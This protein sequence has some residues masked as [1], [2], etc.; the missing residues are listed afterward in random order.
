MTPCLGDM[1][2]VVRVS[3]GSCPGTSRSVWCWYSR[4]SAICRRR[5]GM[6]L[7]T[8]SAAAMHS[9]GAEAATAHCQPECHVP[10]NSSS[11][12]YVLD[13]APWP[14]PWQSAARCSCD[15]PAQQQHATVMALTMRDTTQDYV[16]K[17][18]AG[19]ALK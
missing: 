2:M 5:R 9:G 1:V 12:R 8:G 3:S 18:L 16:V 14:P 6:A 7:G 19:M 4:I 10:G 17:K 13:I 11:G 15:R